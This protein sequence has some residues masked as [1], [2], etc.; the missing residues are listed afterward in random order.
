MNEQ[1]KHPLEAKKSWDNHVKKINERMLLEG[2]NDDNQTQEDSHQDS[3]DSSW[4]IGRFLKR[5]SKKSHKD[6][7]I[8]DKESKKELR[9]EEK[10]KKKRDKELEDL[11]EDSGIDVHTMHGMMIDAGSSGSRLHVYEFQPRILRGRKETELAVSGK[12]LS[13]PGTVSRWTD[14]LRP[15]IA[16]LAS[17]S[18][19]DIV[20][21]MTEYLRPLLEFAE[22]VLSTKKEHWG[23]FPIYLKA[24]AGMRT[25]DK[26]NRLR[27][28][29]ACREVLYNTTVNSFKF[30]TEQARVI[31][32]EEEAIYGWTATNFVLGTLIQSSEG[33]GAVINPTLTHGSIEIGGA[34][35]QIAFYQNNEDI[36][37]NLFK[38]QIGQ[39][40]HWNVYAHSYLYFGIDE[41]YNRLGALLATGQ[42]SSSSSSVASSVYNPCLPGGSQIS[43]QSDIYFFE[44]HETRLSVAGQDKSYSTVL[45][46][47]HSTGDYQQ[48]S[49]IA[50][51]LV[52]KRYN[53][54][55][56]F[57]H[58]GSCGFNG[59][60][61]PPIPEQQTGTFGEFLAFSNYFDVLN[62]MNVAENKTNIAQ[63]QN[64]T[65]FLCSMSHKDLVTFNAGRIDE[66]DALLMCFRAAFIF[67][68]LVDGY[69]F[70]LEHN[71]T[72]TDVVSGQKVG[73]A[74]GSML[75]EINTLPWTYLPKHDDEDMEYVVQNHKVFS[76]F[77]FGSFLFLLIALFWSVYNWK[78]IHR[79][80]QGY[81]KVNSIY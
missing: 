42:S 5:K 26:Y 21:A 18:D 30:E 76:V 47:D 40:K 68:L 50:N 43:F 70:K 57:A 7:K 69:G 29:N 31:S 36:M 63:L 4:Y 28:I 8:K 65:R 81:S 52:N 46:N 37:A 33:S 9:T 11:L 23:E 72:A 58:H 35:A 56:D 67:E 41:A 79:E 24:T 48:C 80:R 64:A 55:C 12:K 77:L 74:L 59:V 60:Y 6:K 61:Q 62:F 1:Y 53:T 17:Y 71:I 32:G 19:D 45:K 10:N 38:L 34:S 14:R 49:A 16:Q 73:W 66:N 2:L 44:G 51:S 54:W 78:K 25:L 27:V 20:P 75:Y 15:G 13:Y 22:T 3:F 39:G